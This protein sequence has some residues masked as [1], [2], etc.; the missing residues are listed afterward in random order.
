MRQPLKVL[1]TGKPAAELS[2]IAPMLEGHRQIRVSTARLNG[3]DRATFASTAE[4]YDALIL[5]VD[6][7]WRAQLQALKDPACSLDRPLLVIGPA[8]DTELM[9]EAMRIGGRDFFSQPV[10]ATDLIGALERLA[11]EVH[12]RRGGLSARVSTF[13]NAKGGSGASFCAANYAHAL[14]KDFGHHSILLDFELQFG[15]LPTYFNLQSRNGLIR[16]LELVETLDQTALQGYV[17]RHPSGLDLLTSAAEGLLLTEDVREE[18]VSELFHVIDDAYDEVVVDLPRRIDQ[19]NAAVLDRSDLIF[20]VAQ[21]SVPHLHEL[22]RLSELLI[23]NL[24]IA[25]HR[26]VVLINRYQKHDSVAEADFENALPGVEIVRLPNDHK[27]V[28]ESINLGIPMLDHAPRSP[29][30]KELRNMV[31]QQIRASEEPV[32]GGN[33]PP[34][35]SGWHLFGLGA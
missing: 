34:H 11:Q 35:K 12:E 1:I 13:M 7:G 23:G 17:Q 30:T 16:A 19:A 6:E 14:V 33:K 25:K 2:E 31:K 4:R 3:D 10:S 15:S 28:N 27:A 18:P 26:L 21:Q 32:P 5:V 24:G 8:K 9:R 29:F 22:K 20:L